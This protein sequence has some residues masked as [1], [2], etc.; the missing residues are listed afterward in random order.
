MSFDN[1]RYLFFYVKNYTNTYTT[2]GYTLPITPFTFIP[3]L[4]TGDGNVVS[5]TNLLW[6][7]GDGTTSTDITAT[8]A[9][10]VP[11][12]YNVT[13]HLYSS[14]G[15][16]YES[17]FTQSVFVSD[18]ITDS[19]ALCSKEAVV[20]EAGHYENP[21]TI[22]RFN[23]WQTYASLG[24]AGATV[25]FYASGT[26]APLFDAEKYE[27]EKYAH[28]RPY[29][30]F[31]VYEYNSIIEKDEL[32]PVNKTKTTN[33]VELYVKLKDNNI[34][35]C[36]ST[37]LGSTLAGTSGSKLIYFTDD[38][39]QVLSLPV[40]TPRYVLAMAY[41]DSTELYDNDS[42]GKL[43]PKSDYQ[44]L[45]QIVRDVYTPIFIDQGNLNRLS[46]TS[47]GIDG[48]G[49]IDQSFGIYRNKYVSQKIPFVIRIKDNQEF[50]TKSANLLRYTTTTPGCN[51]VKI[52]LLSSDNTPITAANFYE[53]FQ[54]F[55]NEQHGGFFKGYLQCDVP[56][57]G[58]KIAAEAKSCGP[59]Y[60]MIPTYHNIISQPQSKKLH[61]VNFEKR[62]EEDPTNP[63][64]HTESTI[65]TQEL[66][67]TPYLTGAY[68]AIVVPTFYESTNVWVADADRDVVYK[69][70]PTGEVLLNI[71]LPE[72]SSPSNMVADES[73]NVWLSLY[74]GVSTVKLDGKTG[75]I[76][77]T[78]A[79]LIENQDYTDTVYYT[80]QS[81][82][83]GQNLIL[84]TSVETDRFNNLWVSYSNPL[85]SMICKYDSEGV[86]LS[87]FNAPY[88]YQ[89]TEI[90]TTNDRTLWIIYKNIAPAGYDKIGK[91]TAN[92]DEAFFDINM[93]LWNI[94]CDANQNI[95]ATAGRSELI[96][97][98]AATGTF[99]TYYTITSDAI[100]TIG[101]LA[102]IGCTTDNIILV[103]DDE[104]K[105][106]H[107]FDVNNASMS[108]ISALS[109]IPLQTPD[110]LEGAR[111]NILNAFG[112]WTG[113]RYINKYFNRVGV[114]SGLMGESDTFSIYP[115]S[116]V[117]SIGKK[118][119]NFN[120]AAQYQA[121][122]FQEPYADYTR[123]M[124]DFLGTAVGNK[125]APHEA[126]GKRT[127][128]KISNFVDN[129][130]SIDTCNIEALKSLH[131]LLN[132]NFYTMQSYSFDYPSN[133]ARLIDLFSIKFSKLRGSR[134]MYATNFNSKGFNHIAEDNNTIGVRYGRNRGAELDI[135]T[136][137]LTGGVDGYLV[138]F[139]KFSEQYHMVC[140]NLP[141]ANY[142]PYIDEESQTYALSS[143]DLSGRWGWGL[144]LPSNAVAED[145]DK[146]YTF[147]EY[148]Y[149]TDDQQVAG[150]INW[151]DP[152]TTIM[153]SIST[154]DAWNTLM[155]DMITYTLTEGL[156][157]LSATVI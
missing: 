149:T 106:L 7:F 153:E 154:M 59:S 88:G 130:N 20:N 60:F 139:E 34:V 145:L 22:Y 104:R 13:C 111:Q 137:V 140:T 19:L 3:V 2:T 45:R 48:E 29:A 25:M 24:T 5:N 114:V 52:Q 89:P 44:I 79:P 40:N 58:V 122:V 128:E 78:A 50:T 115:A 15:Q 142:I 12:T 55:E 129:I 138:A 105:C 17:S 39:V 99:T 76:I 1:T 91:I 53:D 9:Y 143:Y 77:A 71:S 21:F 108:G 33:N 87:T 36:L 18:Y 133:I 47:S 123:L 100:D 70:R 16:G 124:T 63:E 127:Y 64:N 121:Y 32:I 62:K 103:V 147:Y 86:M 131:R 132:E 135:Y 10:S 126:V 151:S 107:Y 155:E 97:L 56:V 67:N 51:Q 82:H 148:V 141:K 94:T 57:Y 84:P 90:I 92:G 6:H 80:P 150:L 96:Y 98:S 68:T 49:M 72:G 42:Y 157:L 43:F 14:G 119:E 156:E 26:G 30:R 11:G 75:E 102:G 136:T 116:G 120:A 69:C 110:D 93:P 31:L 27:S 23:S 61:L 112:D 85:L 66:I 83:A 152:N 46:I 101:E 35:P 38:I 144:V 146:Y 4:D 65:V 118:N 73:R 8:H 41:F 134:N 28:L 37:D 117:L 74:D 81:G 113:F 95:W 54:E 125:Y 109:T